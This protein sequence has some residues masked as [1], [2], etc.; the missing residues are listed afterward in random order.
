MIHFVAKVFFALFL[1]SM[2]NTERSLIAQPTP[3]HY[4][5]ID[6]RMLGGEGGW[7]YLTFDEASRH[8][9]ISHATHVVVYDVDNMKI[10]GDIAHTEGVHGIAVASEFG[11]GFISNGKS[12]TVLM[13]DLKN[14]DTLMRISVGQKPDA[15]IYDPFSKTVIACNG[16]S[17][18]AT[19]IDA[20]TGRVKATIQLGGGPEFAV[21]DLSGNIYI[22]IEDKN[23]VVKID[24]KNFKVLHHWSLGAG[25]GPTGIAMD[26]KTH[27][28]FIGCANKMMVIVNSEN[29]KV[30]A[31]LPIG[32]G[33][34]AVVFDAQKQEAISSNGEGTLSIIK[35]ISKD[36]FEVAETV[37][38]QA[39][40][41]TEALD[42]KTHA[43]YL[44]TSDFGLA[45]EPTKEHPHPRPSLLPN[46]FRLLKFGY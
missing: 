10:V 23:E 27:R 18:N 1:L 37:P 19:I 13:F 26:M 2:T 43:L 6:T 11:H 12:N 44:V 8:L 21:S 28:L 20:S 25:E 35:E 33:V 45:P 22:N 5:L 38:T 42:V 36:K 24:M 3:E 17:E 40:A 30:I 9:Y 46:T 34:D 29:G 32:K 15:I 39:G 41:R 7:D 31:K 14:L 16:G 4:H